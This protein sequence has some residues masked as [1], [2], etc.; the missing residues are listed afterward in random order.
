[1]ILATKPD[2]VAGVLTEI[3]GRFHEKSASVISIAA[4]VTLAKLEAALPAGARVIR[5]MPNTAGAGQAGAAGFSLGKKRD[6]GGDGELGEEASLG[7]GHRDA[8]EVKKP[9]G[10]GDRLERERAGVCVSIHRGFV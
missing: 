7:S 3:F 9:A 10:R 6:G 8:G 5:V 4:G 1:M 2:Q